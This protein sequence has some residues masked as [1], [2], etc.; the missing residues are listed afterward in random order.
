MPNAGEET[1]SKRQE[2][3]SAPLAAR[4]SSAVEASQPEGSTVNYKA[5][6]D[7]GAQ[8]TATHSYQ[9]GF[10]RG[11]VGDMEAAA[12]TYIESIKSEPKQPEGFLRL[13]SAYL[14]LKRNTDAVNAF[15]QALLLNPSLSEAQYGLGLSFF[16]L[17]R[18]RNAVAAFKKAIIL[19][20]T[21]AKAHFGLGMAY[22][23]LNENSSVLEE[24]KVLEHLDKD[25]AK[26]LAQS[27]RNN[28][29]GCR[30]EGLCK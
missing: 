5:P 26:S 23:E 19:D 22:Q 8:K 30:V 18:L 15:K 29:L 27:F 11:D 4:D 6:S 20:P 24:Y 21:M 16:R 9:P 1:E 3:V 2:S 13:G 10:E 17:N 25:L 14:K 7:V 12:K 28:N